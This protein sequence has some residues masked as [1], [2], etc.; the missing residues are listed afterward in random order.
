MVSRKRCECG[1]VRALH[2]G[3]CI[4]CTRNGTEARHAA[5]RVIVA[6]GKCPDCGQRLKRNRAMA[7]WW[8]CVR[9]A[10]DGIYGISA[11]E[12]SFQIFTE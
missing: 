2:A 9:Y 11:R 12:C 6:A 3:Q 4:E 8:Q 10:A 7:G 1:R 5:A